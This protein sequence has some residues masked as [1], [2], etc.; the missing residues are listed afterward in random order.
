MKTH[1][2]TK[3]RKP[4]LFN[5][6]V[7]DQDLRL[8]GLEYFFG[9]ERG[10]H[11]M[12]NYAK[13]RFENILLKQR[14]QALDA[15]TKDR[16]TMKDQYD[17]TL[18]DRSKQITVATAGHFLNALKFNKDGA[19]KNVTGLEHGIF[20][21]DMDTGV[22]L[23]VLPHQ[24]KLFKGDTKRY[25]PNNKY[26]A[27]DTERKIGSSFKG[28]YNHRILRTNKQKTKA[29]LVNPHNSHFPIYK[30]TDNE[31]EDDGS[32]GELEGVFEG[33][34]ELIS[35]FELLP[36]KGILN[37]MINKSDLRSCT[38]ALTLPDAD[39]MLADVTKGDVEDAFK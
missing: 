3:K 37:D 27:G 6:V 13:P 19:T 20:V 2:A 28:A 25:F 11:E 9:R 38:P 1:S 33:N 26:D 36:V 32:T 23:R 31:D 17:K 30:G 5:D 39:T 10:M 14:N 22:P 4:R 34:H 7:A 18:A 16:A 8:P 24:N 21:R 29:S 15:I 35:K 12:A